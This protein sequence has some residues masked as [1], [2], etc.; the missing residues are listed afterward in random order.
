M[1]R[2]EMQLLDRLMGRPVLAVAHRVVGEDED[3]RQLHQRRQPDR[4]PRVVAEDEEG[5]AESPQLGQRHPVDDRRHGMLADAE[6]QVPAAGTAGLEV[7][8]A[9][10]FQRRLVRGAEVRR[11]ADEPGD[12]LGEHVEHLARGVAPG[13]ALG[14]GREDR[15]IAVPAGRQLA[16][17]HLVDLVREL[18]ELL[19]VV[20]EELVPAR[21][22]LGAA[23]ADA[24]IE[25]LATPSGTR[26]FASS[27][28]P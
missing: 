9:R 24:G 2:S 11:A 1:A 4:R 27:G 21:A 22:R 18:G 16:P 23:R 14:V 15:Q 28:Q 6:M 26:N 3:G 20:G 17:L 8:G 13:D 12:V 10:E 25:M 7:A 19:A 5:R